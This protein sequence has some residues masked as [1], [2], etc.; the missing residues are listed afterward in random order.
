MKK[1]RFQKCRSLRRG[2]WRSCIGMLYLQNYK[3]LG[4]EHQRLEAARGEL[5]AERTE[6][7]GEIA[8]LET[9]SAE[10][11]K[12]L[13]EVKASLSA[14]STRLSEVEGRLNVAVNESNAQNIEMATLTEREAQLRTQ[15][16]EQEKD[17]LLK[18]VQAAI[19]G[20]RGRKM[21]LGVP[22]E[23]W[24]GLWQLGSEI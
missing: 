15:L 11:E 21:R 17:G 3:A 8:S 2:C 9:R 1:F 14:T 5:E 24:T 7:L 10:L 22:D 6:M 16:Q 19:A 4:G 12:S 18:Q 20:V 13:V 23:M